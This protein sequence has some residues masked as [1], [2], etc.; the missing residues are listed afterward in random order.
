MKKGM[1]RTREKRDKGI[2]KMKKKNES[3]RSRK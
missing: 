1:V 2:E 3:Q